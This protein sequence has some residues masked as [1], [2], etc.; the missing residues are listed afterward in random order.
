MSSWRLDLCPVQS[1]ENLVKNVRNLQSHVISIEIFGGL[2][3][4]GLHFQ[5]QFLKSIHDW[6]IA[7]T[8]ERFGPV[9]SVELGLLFDVT[10]ASVLPAARRK[11]GLVLHS[12]QIEQVCWD[13]NWEDCTSLETLK[14]FID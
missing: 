5:G 14:G 9:R 7:H 8:R 10:F 13:G 3:A 1:V 11:A 2:A 6:I 4:L 12:L